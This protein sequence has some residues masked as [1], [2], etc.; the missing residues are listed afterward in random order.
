MLHQL[1]PSFHFQNDDLVF[2]ILSHILFSIQHFGVFWVWCVGH[3]SGQNTWKLHVCVHGKLDYQYFF[4]NLGCVKA[5]EHAHWP[6]AFC[7][8]F[9]MSW[10]MCKPMMN[11]AHPFDN[12]LYPLTWKYRRPCR[13]LYAVR[14]SMYSKLRLLLCMV[15]LFLLLCKWSCTVRQNRQTW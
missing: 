12:N 15:T 9:L 3:E 14:F 5:A 10:C 13:K 11:K 2:F 4:P 7:Y 8:C 6:A 1:L